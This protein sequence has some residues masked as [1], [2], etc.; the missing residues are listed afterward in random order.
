MGQWGTPFA[1]LRGTMK[2]AVVLAVTLCVACSRETP[3]ETAPA[4]ALAPVRGAASL[5][6]TL[7]LLERELNSAMDS[8]DRAERLVAAEAITDRLLETQLPFAWLTAR[9]YGVQSLLRQIQSLA[10]R[11]VAELRSGE[12]TE[13]IERDVRDLK[14]KVQELRAGLRAGG[15]NPP[16]S[17][18]SLLAAYAADSLMK[19]QDQGE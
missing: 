19:L 18:D 3:E 5:E 12:K 14:S 7:V 1:A 2:K 17:L 8:E 10:D 11:I 13:I 9:A 6:S 15:G 4:T 16:I